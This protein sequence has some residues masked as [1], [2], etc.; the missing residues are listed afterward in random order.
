MIEI[1]GALTSG[2]VPGGGGEWISIPDNIEA[3]AYVDLTP[4]LKELI[5]NDNSLNVEVISTVTT[6]DENGNRRESLP[7]SI[8]VNSENVDSLLMVSLPITITFL[9][10]ITT[11]DQYNLKDG[12][13][14]PI[15]FTVRNSTTDE[16]IYDDTVNVTITNSTGHLVTYFTNGTSTDS[17]RINSTEEQYIANFCTKDYDLKVGETYAVTVTFGELDSL[18][19]Y[20][21][22]YFTLLDGGK[23]KGKGS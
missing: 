12:S 4:E 23:A 20:E 7:I 22:T 13:T 6:Y 1:D 2:D 9:P 17:V 3:E 5:K 14:L 16:F 10:P 21:I 15:K 18:V 11:M 8:N 19:G